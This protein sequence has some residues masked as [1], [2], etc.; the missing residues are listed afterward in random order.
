MPRNGK[1]Y[2]TLNTEIKNN[3]KQAKEEWINEKCAEIEKMSN[4]NAAS[5]HNRIIYRTKDEPTHRLYKIIR[6]ITDNRRKIF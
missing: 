5:V 2:L 1:E 4:T 6:R 3:C